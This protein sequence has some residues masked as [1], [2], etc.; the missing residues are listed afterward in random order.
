MPNDETEE[1]TEITTCKKRYIYP[2]K[3]QKGFNEWRLVPKKRCIFL[4][5][6]DEL[7]LMLMFMLKKI[8]IYQWKVTNYR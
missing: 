2:E 8:H 5:I 1:D 6:I 7:M 4:E 3:R